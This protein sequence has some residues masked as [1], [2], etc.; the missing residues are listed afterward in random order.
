MISQT[1]MLQN[2]V[3]RLGLWRSLI[4]YYGIPYRGRRLV[5]F[6]RPFIKPGDL[7]FDVGAHVG[8][9]LRAW[10]SLE[11]RIVGLEPQPYLMQFLKKW[12]GQKDNITLIQAAVGAFNG[13]TNMYVSHLTPTVSSLSKSWIDEI[14]QDQSFEN[15]KWNDTTTVRLTTLDQLI[16][17]YG[18]PVICKIDVEG[19][20]L[21]VLKGLTKPIP[22][23]SFEFI[24][25]AIELAVE[26]INRLSTLNKYEY[27]W[28]IA[29]NYQFCSGEWIN[30]SQMIQTLRSHL[31]DGRSGDI[32]ARQIKL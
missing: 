12:Y 27:N 24:P 2:M 25:S 8:N 19:Y 17:N 16:V 6:Y 30:E 26:C 7:C 31:I 20:E 29:E 32:Y 14:S 22:I 5:N 9:R 10:S 11:A 1:F 18:T 13:Q 28:L 3:Q 15:V 4:I 21:E 23:I